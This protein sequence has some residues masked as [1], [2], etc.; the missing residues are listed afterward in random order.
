MKVSVLIL[1][2][3]YISASYEKCQL[4]QTSMT[5]QP[6]KVQ[7]EEEETPELYESSEGVCEDFVGKKVCCR[8]PGRLLMMIN[9]AKL[10]ATSNC[11]T[12]INNMKRF[13]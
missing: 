10:E 1:L 5:D 2:A 3:I 8:A 6:R 13:L 4:I 7:N 11:Q 9:F 12:C